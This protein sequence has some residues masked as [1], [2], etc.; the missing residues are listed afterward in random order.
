MKF[1]CINF[2]RNIENEQHSINCKF[3]CYAQN[4]L[5]ATKRFTAVTGY[6][7]SCIVNIYEV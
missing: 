1:Y 3:F 5:V 7:Q 4:V 6:K 2:V